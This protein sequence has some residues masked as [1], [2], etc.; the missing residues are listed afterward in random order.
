M[1]TSGHEILIVD[2]TPGNLL[3][4]TVIFTNKGYKVRQASNG[5]L[6]L[7]SMEIKAPDLVLLDINMPEM[8]GYEVCRRIKS[9]K[10]TGTVPVIF[11]SAFSEISEKVKGFNAGGVD[12]ITKPFEPTEV[13]ARA[14]T[15]I[16]LRE[17]TERLEQKV[18]E[19]TRDLSATN[20]QLREAL[21]ERE[22][23]LKEVHHR[24]K[25]NLQIISSLLDLQSESIS[26]HQSRSIFQE[27]RNRIWSMA[28]IHEM[29]YDTGAFMSIDFGRYL[30]KLTE[31][32]FMC[33][34][35][36]GRI[37]RH[38]EVGDVCLGLDEAI[39]CGL[40]VNELVSNA[41]K[42]AFPDGRAGEVKVVVN[43]ADDGLI[44]LTVEDDGVGLPQD[45]DFRET[46]TLGLQLVN[47]LVKQMR[48]TIELK[49]AS[50]TIFQIYVPHQTAG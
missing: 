13:L 11:I 38:V 26:D 35:P 2:D 27:S 32:L 8:D 18:G 16:R 49:N 23:L 43:R 3:L 14:A 19:A 9:D 12:Y 29:L 48:G 24:V 45:L 40:I 41:L 47:L 6:A 7:R 36:D 34:V 10:R 1:D 31:S 22:V 25:N 15:H 50:G 42:Y 5:R 44:K 39:P 33:Y 17:L 4:L 37:A 28:M 20:Q 21:A 46:G 30:E